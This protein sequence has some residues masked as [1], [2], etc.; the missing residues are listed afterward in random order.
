VHLLTLNGPEEALCL[1]ERTLAR[2]FY[3]SVRS[4]V[5]P[6]RYTQRA[7]EVTLRDSVNEF[8]HMSARVK[9][10]LAKRNDDRILTPGCTLFGAKSFH[11]IY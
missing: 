5:K 11:R 10:V 2:L 8:E 4:L 3:A 6:D 1:V 9:P 7:Q